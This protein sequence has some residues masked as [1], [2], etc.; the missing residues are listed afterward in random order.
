VK[1]KTLSHSSG[2]KG[3]LRE[4]GQK[5]KPTKPPQKVKLSVGRGKKGISSGHVVLPPGI[6]KTQMV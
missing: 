4:R 6:G 1:E 2:N 3:C 5:L